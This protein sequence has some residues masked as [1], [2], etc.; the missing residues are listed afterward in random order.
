MKKKGFI[1]LLL[2]G[3]LTGAFA[4]N[5]KF[6]ASVYYPV[7][8]GDNFIQENYASTIGVGAHYRF[9]TSPLFSFDL[10]VR[11]SFLS[12]D[13]FNND[14][15]NVFNFQP[16]V[17]TS[18]NL[19]NIPRLKPK[20]G[21]GYTFLFFN[22]PDIFNP[23]VNDRKRG[24]NIN[25]GFTYSIIRKLS[26]LFEYDYTRLDRE[27]GIPNIS[28]NKNVIFLNIGLSYAI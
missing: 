28:F 14:K 1:I 3:M 15:I 17:F 10:S 25:V 6:G 22:T 18:L 12:R 20:V 8:V 23:A 24:Y 11:G 2:L 19:T 4:Q 13:G 9:A 21:L 5:S 16:S 26:L 7:P 27:R